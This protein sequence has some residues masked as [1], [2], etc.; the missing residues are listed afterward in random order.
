MTEP[1]AYRTARAINAAAAAEYRERRNQAVIAAY[2]AGETR[3]TIGARHGISPRMV[4]RI[5]AAA[6]QA[7]TAARM[8]E[9]QAARARRGGSCSGGRPKVIILADPD[10]R[11][12]SY[13]RKTM[14][15]AFARDA[16]GIPA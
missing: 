6:G 9:L 7:M 8:T 16:F 5:A 1:K 11:H 3:A 12:Y 13:L 10:M 2:I 4:S 15:A 14:G